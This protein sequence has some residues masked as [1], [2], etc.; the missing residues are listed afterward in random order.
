MKKPTWSEM[1]PDGRLVFYEGNDP[2]GFAAEMKSKFGLD[3][4]AKNQPTN[5]LWGKPS[6]T[7]KGGYSFHCPG[8]LMDEIYGNAKYPLGS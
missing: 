5:G 1:M 3:V 7:K 6:F 8:H 2:K 4:R